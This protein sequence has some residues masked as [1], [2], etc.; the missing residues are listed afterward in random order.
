MAAHWG[1]PGVCGGGGIAIDT[2]L[3][4]DKG[5]QFDIFRETVKTTFLD[6]DHEA[7]PAVG[8]VRTEFRPRSIG[9][10][11]AT[12][13]KS[14]GQGF[15][16]AH[17]GR[18]HILMDPKDH[19][20]LMLV[21]TGTIWHRQFGRASETA[22]GYMQLI[23]SR[24]DYHVRHTNSS[25]C[26]TVRVPTTLLR[27]ALGTPE[28]YCG[29]A[30]DGRRGTNA[31]L[32]DFL[33]SVWRHAESFTD[34]NESAITARVIEAIGSLCGS[35]ADRAMAHSSAGSLHFA[36]ARRYIQSR[37]K[38]PDLTPA[39]IAGALHIST[40]HLHA[41]M[42]SNNTSAGKLALGLRLDRCRDALGDP[43]WARH[44][45][46]RIALDWG[47]SDPAHFTKTFKAR[48]GVT[49]RRYRSLAASRQ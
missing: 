3:L 13:V 35:V 6:I 7:R 41:V 36:R 1:L 8:T 16:S 42:R 28:R 19:M 39:D 31:V 48:F 49:P 22:P 45:I 46:T 14:S 18:H 4:Q 27:E 11:V 29:I 26:L 34:R 10:L 17:R 30:I 44:T 20:V 23:D 2:V 33:F 47:F 9:S 38:D 43:R 15:A 37:L 12:W 5:R 32:S 25:M 40:S 24:E 21:R